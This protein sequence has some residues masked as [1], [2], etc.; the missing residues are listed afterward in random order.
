MA[1]WY[2]RRDSD[3]RT[4][5]Y[6]LSPEEEAEHERNTREAVERYEREKKKEGK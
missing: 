6:D 3:E 4:P 5:C 1:G 2:P